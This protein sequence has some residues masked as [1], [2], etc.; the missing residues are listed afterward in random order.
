MRMSVTVAAALGDMFDG[1]HDKKHCVS[2]S[3]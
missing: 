1:L 2:L 3:C